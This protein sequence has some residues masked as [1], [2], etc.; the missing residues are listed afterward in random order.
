[1]DPVAIVHDVSRSKHRHVL[2]HMCGIEAMP[3]RAASHILYRNRHILFYNNEIAVAC[4]VQM[5]LLT[6]QQCV[7]VFSE[8]SE[9]RCIR[10]F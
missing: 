10:Y 8:H 7:I 1:M 6:N 3:D 2:L 9:H 5:S 4:N